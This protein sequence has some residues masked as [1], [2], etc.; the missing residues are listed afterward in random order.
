[1]TAR[2]TAA[3]VARD[4]K[5][6]AAPDMSKVLLASIQEQELSVSVGD[7]DAECGL[8]KTHMASTSTC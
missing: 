2:Y 5:H 7:V 8:L 4:S 1:V 3:L 6:A